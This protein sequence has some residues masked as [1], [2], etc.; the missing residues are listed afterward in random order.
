[1]ITAIDTSVLLDI[2][3]ADPAF[4]PASR[5]L[6]RTCLAEGRVVACDVVWSEVAGVFPNV[7]SAQHQLGELGIE[8][9]PLDQAAAL[10]AGAAW[11]SYRSRGGRRDRM[12]ADF[13]VGAHA[14]SLS[15]RLLTRD[16]GF[17]RAYFKKLKVIDPSTARR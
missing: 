12:V 3:T 6:L 1:M 10:A 2:Y 11:K 15:D 16:R 17:Y 13:L 14:Q 7:A 8:F 9:S 5:E 4:G